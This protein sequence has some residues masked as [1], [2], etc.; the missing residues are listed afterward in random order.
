MLASL[1]PRALEGLRVREAQRAL[2]DV[3]AVRWRLSRRQQDCVRLL[4]FG[5]AQS[6][7]AVRLGVTQGT[8]D[9]HLR[10]IRERCGEV[11]SCGLIQRLL[12][13][14]LEAGLRGESW[15]GVLRGHEALT[16]VK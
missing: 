3:F 8:V 5:V 7:L 12:G 6:E 16:L 11:E 4:A 1:R 14:A 2:A 13:L 10:A 15:L 9:Q